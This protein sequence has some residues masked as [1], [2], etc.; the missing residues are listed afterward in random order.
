MATI[1]VPMDDTVANVLQ[2]GFA[3]QHQRQNAM[4]NRAM[5]GDQNVAELLRLGAARLAGNL[6]VSSDILN[7]RSTGGQPQASAADAGVNS[8]GP[9]NK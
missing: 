1:P 7:N 5:A 9:V 4:E 3:N 6:G 2:Q 8:G